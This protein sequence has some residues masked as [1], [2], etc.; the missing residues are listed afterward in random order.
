MVTCDRGYMLPW[1]HV[2]MV[3]CN[4]GY[5]LPWLHVTVVTCYHGYMLPWLHVTVVVHSQLSS[6]VYCLP[7]TLRSVASSTR[8]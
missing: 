8:H 6:P 2:I 1:L 3:T 7:C 5:M 4:H